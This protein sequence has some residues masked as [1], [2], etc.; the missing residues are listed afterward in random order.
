MANKIGQI[1]K[2]KEFN[3]TVI[4]GS[5]AVPD[6]QVSRLTIIS[7]PQDEISVKKDIRMAG[8]AA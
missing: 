8:D 5:I 3:G 6:V 7:T 2:F 4:K 1:C